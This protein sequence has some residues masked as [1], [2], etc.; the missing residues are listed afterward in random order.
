MIAVAPYPVRIKDETTWIYPDCYQSGWRASGRKSS[1]Y[2]RELVTLAR[3]DRVNPAILAYV[4][5]LCDL[6]FVLARY[7][8]KADRRRE[9]LWQS[10]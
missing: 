10:S 1:W 9:V 7:L 4:N 5:R 3:K 2:E 6:L 8:N